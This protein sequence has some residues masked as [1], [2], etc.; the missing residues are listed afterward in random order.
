MVAFGASALATVPLAAGALDAQNPPQPGVV[1]VDIST[2]EAL[3][4]KAEAL[5]SSTP[6]LSP[7][8]QLKLNDEHIPGTWSKSPRDPMLLVALFKHVKVKQGFR[9][10]AY[11]WLDEIGG[12]ASVYGLPLN[13]AWPEP[14]AC[15]KSQREPGDDNI[16]PYDYRFPM[17]EGAV[18]DLG[19]ILEPDGTAESYAQVAILVQELQELGAYWHGRGWSDCH[20]VR[21]LPQLRLLASGAGTLGSDS[22]NSVSR[23]IQAKALK[24]WQWMAGRPSEFGVRVVFGGGEAVVRWFTYSARGIE[25]VARWIFVFN[26]RTG[27][28]LRQEIDEVAKGSVGF[29]Y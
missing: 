2:L 7:T 10:V 12:Y 8:G 24:D 3:R 21:D 29:I 17:P 25:S 22:R 16:P 4:A 14:G 20:L 15:M 6:L 19:S 9:L 23:V 5:F 27:N 13:Q 11:Q 28:L 18:E 1:R 26:T